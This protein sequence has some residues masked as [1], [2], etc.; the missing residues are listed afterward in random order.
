MNL[1]L[2]FLLS[3]CCLLCCFPAWSLAQHPPGTQLPIR[4]A[5]GEIVLDGVLDEAD[6]ESAFVA[7][8]WYL[9]FPVDTTEA[10]VQTEA[11]LTFDENFLYVA[12]YCE[13]DTTPDLINSLRR[14]FDYD[15]NDN[16]SIV[17]SPYNDRLNGFFFS[18]TPAG[19][20]MEGIVSAGGSNGGFN[21]FWDN[22]WFSQTVRYRDH[23][24][25]EM[26]IPFNSFRYKSDISEWN[27]ALVR[28]DRKRNMQS[29]WVAT[30]IQFEPGALAFSG[31]LVWQD[32]IPPA[33]VNMSLIPYLAG[34][35]AQDFENGD[36]SVSTG[37]QPG[38]DGK[39]SVTPSL[40]L[41]VTVNPDF[42]QVEVDDQVINL[43]R[44]E[45]QLPERRQFFLENSDLLDN[46][47]FPSARPFFSR[48]IGL[49]QDSV[50]LFQPV[51]ILYGARLSGSLNPKWRINVLNMQTRAA[52]AQ[53]LPSQNYSV[54]AIQRNFGAQSSF[55]LSMVNK[56]SLGVTEADTNRFFHESVF[57]EVKRGDSVVRQL[58]PYNRAIT[59]DLELLSKDNRWYHSSFISRS[60]AN[61][62][63]ANPWAG[64]AFFRFSD[65]NLEAFTGVN[66]IGEDYFA[67]AGFVPSQRV[68]PG[69]I[70]GFVNVVGKFFPSHPSIVVMG[71]E[72][73]ARQVYIP[74]GTQTDQNYRLGYSI[75]FANT[76]QLSLGYNYT[77]QRLTFD[78]NPVS[79]EAIPFLT[80]ETYDWSTVSMEYVSDA[81]RLFNVNV[82]AVY[83]G[84]YNGTNLNLNGRLNFRYQPFG[85]ISLQFD[86]NNVQLADG[87]GQ[88]QLFLIGPRLDLTFTDQ[89]FLTTYVQYNNRLNNLNLNARFQWRYQPASDF[90]I[91]Y[92][93][94]Y[95]PTDFSS[96]NRALVFKL[97]YWLNL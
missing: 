19:V 57:Q 76:S 87:Y 35:G 94:N 89:L 45:I 34:R 55:A 8:D 79:S 13:D 60:F 86:Y 30:P 25:V 84:F 67:E 97:V 23:W 33:G 90:F 21:A 59:A 39:I 93:E 14:D 44:F 48:R 31:Q 40:N 11:R 54:A 46:A 58:N 24:I 16:V 69:Q 29:S 53:G 92:T 85:N 9:N 78:F 73:E 62:A 88:D 49:V 4:Q 38:F 70:S 20:Q 27:I 7:K 41:D 42:S 77:F 74:D 47:G 61:Y 36:G 12:F 96:K 63:D 18:M 50:G 32:P 65:R 66:F 82:E 6:W 3:S 80:G 68:Y 26:A 71:P 81:R 43:T 37:L 52:E 72:A 5:K 83:G 75:S 95:L 1:Y 2:R 10:P 64:S 28:A 15:L 56:Q 51:P 91:V 22:K 17:F